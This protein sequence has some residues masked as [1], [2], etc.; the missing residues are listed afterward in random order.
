MVYSAQEKI[1]AAK[2][3]EQAQQVLRELGPRATKAHNDAVK[4]AAKKYNKVM[5]K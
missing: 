3:L 5:G 4:A 1:N 2:E